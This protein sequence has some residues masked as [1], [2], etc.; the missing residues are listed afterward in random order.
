M[1]GSSGVARVCLYGR[2]RCINA[3]AEGAIVRRE[4]PHESFSVIH[5]WSHTQTTDMLWV[6]DERKA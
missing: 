3:S 5:V 2:Q 1:L 4:V 6:R